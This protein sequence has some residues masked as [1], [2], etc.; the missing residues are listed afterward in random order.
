M[1]S[2]HLQHYFQTLQVEHHFGVLPMHN[3][4]KVQ[5]IRSTKKLFT[6]KN[7]TLIDDDDVNLELVTSNR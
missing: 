2:F 4:Q 7:E 3:Q 6:K 1:S 5:R